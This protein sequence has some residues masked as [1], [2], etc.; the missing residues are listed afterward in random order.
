ML[1]KRIAELENE[2]E[3]ALV[4]GVVINVMENQIILDDGTGKLRVYYDEPW[5]VHL[6]S[7]VMAAGIIISVDQSFKEMKADAIADVSD[8][9]IKLLK[10]V[11][12]IRDMSKK[13]VLE[14]GDVIG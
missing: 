11:E 9:D 2:G 12:M 1:W 5:K 4:I 10:R 13:L 6:K 7:I 14:K 8:I 3:R